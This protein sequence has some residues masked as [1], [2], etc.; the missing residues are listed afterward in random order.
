[1][2]Q[3]AL[4]LV[5]I[6]IFLIT[7]TSLL[8]PL[9]HVSPAVPAIAT[10]TLLGLAALDNFGWQG[11]GTILFVDWFAQRSPAHRDR[12]VHHEAGH[13]L[14]AHLLDIPVTGYALSAWDAFKQG[15]PGQG[16]V[17][18]NCPEL[19]AELQQG[20]L[21][22][23]LLDRYC[24][25]WMAGIAAEQLVYRNTEGGADDRRILR[26]V[27][28]QLKRSAA[29]AGVKERE[30]IRQAKT[31]LET[32]WSAYEALVMAMK[33]GEAVEACD[34]IIKATIND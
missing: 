28:A 34:R 11:Q 16:G 26:Q 1:M 18:F 29:E 7:L 13:F 24:K 27:L 2:S 22:A 9:V 32:H 23:A 12:V 15:N 10:A 4:N 6:G 5:A 25:I 19:E 17:V 31:L 30:A 21:S 20:K 33:A 8:G 14:V 3:T